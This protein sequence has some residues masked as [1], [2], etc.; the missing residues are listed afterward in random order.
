MPPGSGAE[1]PL[2]LLVAKLLGVLAATEKFV[3]QLNPVS[4]P[5]PMHS[6]YGGMYYRAGLGAARESVLVA[7]FG[8]G[9]AGCM[10]LGMLHRA[11]HTPEVCEA[12]TEVAIPL[13]E[14]T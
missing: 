8:C 11:D 12:A 3:V 10:A 14:A 1:P 6:I 13:L 4:A 5:P 7:T 2:G 9:T